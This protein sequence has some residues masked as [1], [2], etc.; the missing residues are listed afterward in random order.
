[1][2]WDYRIVKKQFPRNDDDTLNDSNPEFLEYQYGV[3][4]VFYDANDKAT[5][6][7]KEPI[8]PYG[9]TVEELISNWVII[10]EAFS[11]PILDFD[12]I[13]EEGAYNEVQEA[14]KDIQD[15]QGNIRPTEELEE[16]GKLISH[17]VVMSD[18]RKKF[19]LSEFD[20]K[21]YRNGQIVE[22]NKSEIVYSNN[23]IGKTTA[24]IF[25]K[26]L[27]IVK[28]NQEKYGRENDE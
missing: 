2:Y 24:E 4:E 8:A 1:M 18:L 15:D 28:E 14:L 9:D 16:E 20:M 26:A 21:E 6:V 25:S 3:H 10:S 19:N 5:M 13:P 17:E 23:F 22:Q 27:E 12:N 7:T 11:K